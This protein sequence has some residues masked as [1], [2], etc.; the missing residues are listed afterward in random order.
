MSSS[1]SPVSPCI[2][3]CAIDPES[4]LCAG[5]RRTLDEIARW[6][7]MSDTERLRVMRALPSRQTKARLPA[8]NV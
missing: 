6:S 1:A 5:C 3:V 8:Q 4:G 2:R 7:V